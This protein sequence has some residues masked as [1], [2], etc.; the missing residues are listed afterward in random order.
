[1]IALLGINGQLE[2][3]GH[4]LVEF[5]GR[6]AFQSLDR[7]DE[8]IPSFAVHLFGGGSITFAA[9]FLHVPAVRATR[10]TGLLRV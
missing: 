1:L 5:G 3:Q 9:I 8:R 4:R 2:G 10:E 6:K 7:L